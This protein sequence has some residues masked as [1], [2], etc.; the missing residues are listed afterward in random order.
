[1]IYLRFLT[2]SPGIWRLNL[3]ASGTSDSFF[4]LWLPAYG[5]LDEDVRL[6]R[7]DPF[8][9]VMGPGNCIHCFTVAV[10]NTANT[11]TEGFS[12][13]GYNFLDL[14]TPSIAAPGADLTAPSYIEGYRSITGASASTAL[15]TGC[16]ALI[17]EWA[18]SLTPPKNYGQNE[19][20][21]F[22][23]RGADRPSGETFPNPFSGYGNLNLE[24]SFLSFFA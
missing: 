22:L 9:T 16:C 6:L 10:N 11:A 2:P 13:R 19:I 12:G 1:M 4:H 7:P 17:L 23:L 21:T 5:T 18:R 14:I 3:T 15:T 20:S 24:Q 8:T